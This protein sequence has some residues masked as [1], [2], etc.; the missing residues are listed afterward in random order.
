M[1][2]CGILVL[3]KKVEVNLVG[4]KVRVTKWLQNFK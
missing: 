1:G 4:L 2:F 3:L